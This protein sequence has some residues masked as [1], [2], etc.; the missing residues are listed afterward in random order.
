M[1]RQDVKR[2]DALKRG[3]QIGLVGKTGRVTGPHLCW[4]MNWFQTRLDA[5]LVVPPRPGDRV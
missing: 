3:D 2:G 5:A 4:R 1:S